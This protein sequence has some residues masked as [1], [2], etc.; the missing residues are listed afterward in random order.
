VYSLLSLQ[1]LT[2][3]FLI[4]RRYEGYFIKIVYWS[5]WKVSSFLVGFERQILGKKT[6]NKSNLM[7]ICPMGAELFRANGRKDGHFRHDE[8]NSHFFFNFTNV[9]TNWNQKVR[10]TDLPLQEFSRLTKFNS[11]YNKNTLP[12]LEN[13]TIP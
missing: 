5:S 13:T 2:E 10:K 3:T 8:G 9:P 12:R 1:L 11:E 7:K 6:S 4:L